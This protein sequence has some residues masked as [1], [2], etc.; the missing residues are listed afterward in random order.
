MHIFSND[1][2]LVLHECGHAKD[3]NERENPS[4]YG[5]VPAAP[6]L[7]NS[8][9]PLHPVLISL[10]VLYREFTASNNT[11]DYLR[12]KRNDKKIRKAFTTLVP[13]F[14]TYV[15]NTLPWPNVQQLLASPKIVRNEIVRKWFPNYLLQV[16]AI[17]I[18]GQA[19]GL[20]MASRVGSTPV[21]QDKEEVQ[22]LEK[23]KSSQVEVP[24]IPPS[25]NTE[26]A[27]LS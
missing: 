4:L 7:L 26:P 24:K 15:V 3:F 2:G 8:F 23:V 21:N 18:A 16:S 6:R 22:E 14:A 13:A 20:L 10:P 11:I 27:P 25:H 9:L 5:V 1:L 12:A 19:V 17:M